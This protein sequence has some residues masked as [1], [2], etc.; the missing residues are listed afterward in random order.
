MKPSSPSR[1]SGSSGNA[2]VG[3]RVPTQY[4]G[5]L[6]IRR[7]S[8]RRQGRSAGHAGSCLSRDGRGVLRFPDGENGHVLRWV[9]SIE[10]RSPL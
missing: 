3:I 1:A 5:E 6:E 9:E 8:G 4:R 10:G 7:E 2:R